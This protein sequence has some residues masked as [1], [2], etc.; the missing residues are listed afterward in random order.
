MGFWGFGVFFLYC[1]V[2]FE[3]FGVEKLFLFGFVGF[4]G[5]GRKTFFVYCVR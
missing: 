2:D 1:V 3:G 4:G 5:L